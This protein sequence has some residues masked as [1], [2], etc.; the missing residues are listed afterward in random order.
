MYLSTKVYGVTA[1]KT[2][3]ESCV[4]VLCQ[5]CN[6]IAFN[7]SRTFIY[8]YEEGSR[9]KGRGGSSRR[10]YGATQIL[11]FSRHFS[12][13]VPFSNSARNVFA[14]PWGRKDIQVT[15][16]DTDRL[17]HGGNCIYRLCGLM[18]RVF[19]ATGPKVLG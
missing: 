13:S 17:R 15:F 3:C 10:F 19:L 12:F 8:L 7:F 9:C 14:I 4:I 6:N 1:L 16:R 18:V 5:I 2:R 11:K